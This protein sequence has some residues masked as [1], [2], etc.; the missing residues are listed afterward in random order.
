MLIWTGHSIFFNQPQRLPSFERANQQT[1]AHV[2]L[3]ETQPSDTKWQ[4]NSIC[5]F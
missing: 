1:D 4:C 5:E 2:K 3:Q